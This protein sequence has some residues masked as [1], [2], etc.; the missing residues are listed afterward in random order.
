MARAHVNQYYRTETYNEQEFIARS[1]NL[2]L[3]EVREVT[4][5]QLRNRSTNDILDSGIYLILADNN[6]TVYIGLAS[7]FYS[8]F[9]TGY[10]AHSDECPENCAHFGHFV[11]PTE[12]SRRVGMPDGNCRFFILE[13]IQHE[14]FGISQAEID[15]FFLFLANGWH[16]RDSP[17]LR[18]ITNYRPSL[19]MKGSRP[20]PCIVVRLATG[21]HN[22]FLGQHDAAELLNTNSGNLPAP[23]AQYQ[24][25]QNGFTGRH[26]T[27]EEILAGTI[28]GERDVTW[29]RGQSG[30]VIESLQEACPACAGDSDTHRRGLRIFW[31]GGRLSELDIAHLQGVRR[32]DDDGTY[33]QEIPQSDYKQVSWD[34][35]YRGGLGGWQTRARRGPTSS[36]RHLWRAGP[37]SAIATEDD[38]ALLRERTILANLDNEDAEWGPWRDF[39]RGQTRGSNAVLLN[40]RLS[41][42]QRGG[43]TFVDWEEND[44]NAPPSDQG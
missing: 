37:N 36:M 25:Q 17:H 7:N 12:G 42:E 9:N 2:D 40:E 13:T 16:D 31:N 19:G 23:I 24:N 33:G 5:Q 1:Q 21:E 43:Q 30:P 8:R 10:T 27:Q 3:N 38:A 18:R 14:G 41:E 4:R 28:V 15:W 11:N 20:A 6:E 35:T 22:Y 26:A 39:C 32:R 34:S 29:R 44:P